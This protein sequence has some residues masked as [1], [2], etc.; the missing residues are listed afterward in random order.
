MLSRILRIVVRSL[1]SP[2]A[3]VFVFDNRPMIKPA[4][5]DKPPIIIDLTQKSPRPILPSRDHIVSSE[6]AGGRGFFGLKSRMGPESS[7]I[8]IS[9]LL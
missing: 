2:V 4:P 6:N 5:T 7:D 9:L 3:I 8:V 1:A